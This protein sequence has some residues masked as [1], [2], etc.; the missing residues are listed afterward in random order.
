MNLLYLAHTVP[1]PPNKGEKIRAF[2]QIRALSRRHRLHVACFARDGEDVKAAEELRNY[3]A[4]VHCEINSFRTALIGAM[5]RFAQGGS[6]NM[7]FY[8]N[9]P[10]RSYVS[11]LCKRVG[12][13]AAIAYALPMAPYAP[14][15][16]K[17]LLDMQDVDSEKWLEYARLRRPRLL[18]KTEANRLRKQ[19][20][21]WVRRVDCT[22]LTSHQ[23]TALLRN[24]TPESRIECIE[25][26]VDADYFD[27]DRVPV[28]QDLHNRRYVVF[29]GTM[30]YFP[31]QEAAKWFA[32]EVFPLLRRSDGKLEFLIVGNRPSEAVR[33]LGALPG[34]RV[35]GGV[36]DVRPYVANA[37]AVTVPLRVA[38]GIQNKVLEA[39]AL[40]RPVY[41][42]AAVCRTFGSKL[43]A[44]VVACGSAEELAARLQET[45]RK[46]ISVD[47]QIREQMRA[48]FSWNTNLDCMLDELSTQECKD[49]AGS[50]RETALCPN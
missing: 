27:P 20:L 31:N 49:S 38:R 13:D 41:T 25:N 34:V 32:R 50:Y 9:A 40:G 47:Y 21:A 7:A 48:R 45:L 43:P 26:G 33:K 15:G 5:L 10:M 39:L 14:P 6:L 36:D 37:D 28:N 35:V 19:E 46:P 2:H 30:D 3:C 16:V 1:F 24:L 8:Q 11:D 17:L 4:S 22:Y 42:T 44:G 23:E 12:M 29:V 18:F